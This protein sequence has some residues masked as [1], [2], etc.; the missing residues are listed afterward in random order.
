MGG[1]GFSAEGVRSPL[2]E[3]VPRAGAAHAAASTG[4]G[5]ASSARPAAT[6]P[7]YRGRFHQAFDD[8]AEAS[9]LTLFDRRGRGHPGVRA[10]PGRDLRRRRQHAQPAGGLAGPRARRALR[11]ATRPASSWAGCRPARSAGSRAGRPTRTAR[12]CS[13]STARSGSSPAA[14][15]RTTTASRSVGRP[16]TRSSAAAGCRPAWPSTTTPRRCSTVRTSS[17]SSPSHAGPTAYR[18]SPDGRGGV[19]ETALPARILP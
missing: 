8:V 14:T 11:A 12:R 19:I 5:S 10:G 13:R 15:R 1:G 2:D 3:R 4:R 6:T 9:H 16:T 17:R 18:V 7:D